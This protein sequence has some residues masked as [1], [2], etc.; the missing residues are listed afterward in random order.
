[1]K[2]K[3]DAKGKVVPVL[4]YVAHREDVWGSGGIAPTHDLGTRGR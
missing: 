4:V 2:C 1:V 3:E